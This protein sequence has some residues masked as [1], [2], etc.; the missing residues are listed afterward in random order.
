[1]ACPPH[2]NPCAS[3]LKPQR[4]QPQRGCNEH[5]VQAMTCRHM[6]HNAEAHATNG[7]A[8]L[9]PPAEVGAGAID[10]GASMS[11]RTYYPSTDRL[12]AQQRITDP[13]A[14]VG[15]GGVDQ[16]TVAVQSLQLGTLP[17]AQHRVTKSYRLR[18]AQARLTR[19]PS[20]SRPSMAAAPNLTAT[21]ML[22]KPSL[23]PTS[24]QRL[25]ANQLRS[26]ACAAAGVSGTQ[27][28]CLQNLHLCRL[29]KRCLIQKQATA[30]LEGLI[31]L[32]K[33]GILAAG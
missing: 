13:L 6:S 27:R 17:L 33:G 12:L 18:L 31:G 2:D 20:M 24:R 15:A 4:F 1:M 32:P 22:T 9:N 25:P 3:P 21:A 30:L 28:S 14:E 23:Q 19:A 10:Q 26:S 11:S 16:G 5:C 8:V 7:S 29:D